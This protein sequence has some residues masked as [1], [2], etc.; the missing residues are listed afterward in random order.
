MKIAVDQKT[1]FNETEQHAHRAVMGHGDPLLAETLLGREESP[2]PKAALHSEFAGHGDPIMEEVIESWDSAA[3]EK[4]KKKWT[5][6]KT[7][8]VDAAA[9]WELRNSAD[10][11]FE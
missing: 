11:L 5:T 10:P 3:K 2:P 9:A 4:L 7:R 1:A 6:K 8:S